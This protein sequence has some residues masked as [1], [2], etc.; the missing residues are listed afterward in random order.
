MNNIEK[1]AVST[2]DP[3]TEADIMD[4]NRERYY[5]HCRSAGIEVASNDTKARIGFLISRW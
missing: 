5:D 3:R 4:E 1:A 2:D